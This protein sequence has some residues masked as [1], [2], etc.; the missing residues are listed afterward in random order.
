MKTL[1]LAA[2]LT[3][4]AAASAA[5]LACSQRTSTNVPDLKSIAAVQPA[6]AHKI[7]IDAVGGAVRPTREGELTTI[8]GC[9]VYRFDM[10]LMNGEH[11]DVVVDAGNGDV[12]WVG[13]APEP[14]VIA[15]TLREPPP[16]PLR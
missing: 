12:L 5:P 8:D 3:V 14:V 11:R 13:G 4:P 15:P 6:K 7:A 16:A 9:L 1:I 2:L 10:E